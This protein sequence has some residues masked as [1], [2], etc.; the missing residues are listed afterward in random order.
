MPTRVAP[1]AYSRSARERL[2]VFGT[3]TV[4]CA[5]GCDGVTV[6]GS[7]GSMAQGVLATLPG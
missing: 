7:I 1:C 4:L 3:L 5:C 6:N 2:Q